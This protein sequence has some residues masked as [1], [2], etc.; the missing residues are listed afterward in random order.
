MILDVLNW[1]HNPKLQIF[2]ILNTF[3]SHRTKIRI[4]GF[5]VSLQNEIVQKN[6]SSKWII[7]ENKTIKTDKLLILASKP[8][9]F[10]YEY[11]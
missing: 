9:I 11:N 5:I 1:A 4:L 6:L 7:I 3:K 10:I 2:N 8:L